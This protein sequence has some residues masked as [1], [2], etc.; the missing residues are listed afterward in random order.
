MCFF[1]TDQIRRQYCPHGERYYLTGWAK[2]K[3]QRRAMKESYEE[4][5]KME[6]A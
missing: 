2:H 5:Q 6:Y 4:Y 1:R 3:K